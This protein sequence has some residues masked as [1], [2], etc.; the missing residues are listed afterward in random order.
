MTS[1][2]KISNSSCIE[3]F[4]ELSNC[5]KTGISDIVN[6]NQFDGEYSELSL[7]NGGGWCRLDGK[8]GKNTK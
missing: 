4:R 6:T 8:F 3:K 1:E 5:D 2:K 7:G